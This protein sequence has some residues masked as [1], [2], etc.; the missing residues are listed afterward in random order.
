MASFDIVLP[1]VKPI[2][3]KPGNFKKPRRIGEIRLGEREKNL[4]KKYGLKKAGEKEE[5][6]IT[7]YE[8]DDPRGFVFGGSPVLSLGVSVKNGKVVSIYA[9]LK[10]PVRPKLEKNFGEG[11]SLGG[12]TCW[13][14]YTTT[15]FLKGNTLILSD[16][17]EALKE[18]DNDQ[19]AMDEAQ[20]AKGPVRLL[21]ECFF[22]PKGRISRKRY[23]VLSLITGVPAFILFVFYWVHPAALEQGTSGIWLLAA[24]A[25]FISLLTLAMRR[26]SDIGKSHLYYW[27]VFILLIGVNEFIKRQWGDELLGTH[28]AIS[29]FFL[30]LI[31]MAF[32][33]GEKKANKYG[34]V[35]RW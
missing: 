31:I 4:S 24:T 35:P 8:I 20:K 29:L 1:D 12:L 9:D 27:L 10:D 19:I 11:N 5:K 14:D 18:A 16:T 15:V 3:K 30:I 7:F 34:P 6:G 26:L 33:P 32:I 25:L 13:A 21:L 23:T 17:D 28:V 22:S 2:V